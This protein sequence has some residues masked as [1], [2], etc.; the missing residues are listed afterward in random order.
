MTPERWFDLTTQNMSELHKVI[1]LIE[2]KI[3]SEVTTSLKAASDKVLLNLIILI[4]TIIIIALISFIIIKSI[5]P[6]LKALVNTLKEVSISKNLTHKLPSEGNDELTHVAL[7]FNSLM[8]SFSQAIDNV[9]DEV[10]NIAKQSTDVSYSTEQNQK[11]AHS[12]NQSTDTISVAINEM[13]AT[14]QEVAALSQNTAEVVGRAHKSSIDSA[15]KA[16]LTKDMMEN[17]LQ[18]LSN[19]ETQVYQLND[20]TAE[21]SNVLSVIQS[22]AEQTNLLALNAAIEAARAGEQG[23]GFAVVADEVRTLASKTQE[24]TQQIRQQIET[25][26]AGSKA[27]ATNMIALKEQGTAA[28]KEVVN[29]AKGVECLREELDNITAMSQQI[30]TAAEEQTVVA[31]EINERIHKIKDDTEALFRHSEASTQACVKLKASGDKLNE[32]AQE[33]DI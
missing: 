23:R 10:K 1:V 30:A 29:S 18:E 24:S 2:D 13:A 5:I 28:V 27:A 22:I 16:S 7:A 4:T 11:L 32:Y 12:Q 9:Q 20:E 6:P 25:L 21:I 14:I 26:Q 17:L 8:Q 3:K 33:F 31:A 15:E 19:T